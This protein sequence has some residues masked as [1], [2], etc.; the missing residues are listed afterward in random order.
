MPMTKD[1]LK[2][3]AVSFIRCLVEFSNTLEALPEE[4]YL[5]MRVSYFDE[6]TPPDYQPE[7]FREGHDAIQFISKPVKVRIGSLKT[8][9]LTLALKFAG[10][11]SFDLMDEA[12]Q[13]DP[14]GDKQLPQWEDKQKKQ[15][16]QKGHPAQGESP[17]ELEWTAEELMIASAVCDSD[18]DEENMQRSQSPSE[19]A[20]LEQHLSTSSLRDQVADSHEDNDDGDDENIYDDMKAFVLAKQR[21]QVRECANKFNLDISRV[22]TFFERLLSEGILSRHGKSFRV[23]RSST[24]MDRAVEPD[25]C[26]SWQQGQEQEQEQEP[27]RSRGE[28]KPLENIDDE[29]I[30]SEMSPELLAP[31]VRQPKVSPGDNATIVVSKASSLQF[32][33]SQRSCESIVFTSSPSS[34]PIAITR[35]TRL[36]RKRSSS[37]QSSTGDKL[38]GNR[39][40]RKEEFVKATNKRSGGHLDLI[41][42][43]GHA[44]PSAPAVDDDTTMGDEDEGT[45]EANPTAVAMDTTIADSDVATALPSNQKKRQ[46]FILSQDGE[47]VTVSEGQRAIKSR[48]KC[49]VIANPIYQQIKDNFAQDGSES[50]AGN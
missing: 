12:H 18:N 41:T 38:G 11:E 32:S 1:T 46:H 9:H 35:T 5:T 29:T 48:K 20:E 31:A 17:S 26:Q 10:L 43:S 47:S 3:Q 16:F 50:F 14:D 13:A 23:T 24:Q 42:R 27:K 28:A 4:R 25:G 6:K 22:H 40:Q 34:P 37:Y 7:F 21:S 33:S 44:N 49:S 8:P 36:Q 15:Q 30:G 19:L 39:R 45:R 2:K